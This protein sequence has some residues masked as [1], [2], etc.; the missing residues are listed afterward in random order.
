MALKAT[1]IY[2]KNNQCFPKFKLSLLEEY[3]QHSNLHK[4]RLLL[5]KK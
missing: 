3:P 1:A 2:F 5:V 4:N